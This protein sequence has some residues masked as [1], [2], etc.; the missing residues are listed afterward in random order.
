M[1]KH[2]YDGLALPWT[3]CIVHRQLK[4]IKSINENISIFLTLSPGVL[5][6][7]GNIFD[8]S[9]RHSVLLTSPSKVSFQ[10]QT[11][12]H[13]QTCYE[14]L[15]QP[16][17]S[18]PLGCCLALRWDLLSLLSLPSNRPQNI[19]TTKNI[20]YF[21]YLFGN[22]LYWNYFNKSLPSLAGRQTTVYDD[23]ETLYFNI[24]SSTVPAGSVYT[25]TV[26]LVLY[27]ATVIQHRLRLIQFRK[28]IITKNKWRRNNY[29][30]FFLFIADRT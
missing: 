23:L 17:V 30:L 3:T 8:T 27:R 28:Q 26:V 22:I 6:S 15:I 9:H 11:V 2:S 5:Y 24:Y 12:A 1:V 7:L 29:L 16:G 21:E 18:G 4:Q 10:V 13:W 14:N 19:F 25:E 20:S